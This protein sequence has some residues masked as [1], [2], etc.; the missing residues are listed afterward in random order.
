MITGSSGQRLLTSCSSSSPSASGIRTSTRAIS[1]VWVESRSSASVAPPA[2]TTSASGKHSRITWPIP[3]RTNAWSSTTSTFTCSLLVRDGKPRDDPRPLARRRA[4]VERPVGV[5]DAPTQHVQAQM[6]L[7]GI[8]S[9]DLEPPAVVL[10]ADLD[11]VIGGLH[12]NVDPAGVRMLGGVG[13]A[14]TDHRR[15]GL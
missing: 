7:D 6:S 4:D 13:D 15:R 8:P 3:R 12:P 10:D 2:S 1:I 5:G 11:R 9:R 14:L